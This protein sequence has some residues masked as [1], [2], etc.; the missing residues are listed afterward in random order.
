MVG[1]Q[2]Y[3]YTR[4]RRWCTI[5]AGFPRAPVV[6]QLREFES[7]RVHTRYEVVGTF[8]CAPIDSRKAQE[9]ELATFDENRRAVGM[10]NP[11]RDKN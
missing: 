10:L 5:V 8:F 2:V 11:M 7:P 9:R 6:G 3:V 4:S 1:Y